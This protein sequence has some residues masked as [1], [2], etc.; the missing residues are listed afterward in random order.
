[1][2][3]RG[4]MTILR[5]THYLFLSGIF[6]HRH[7]RNCSLIYRIRLL[8][9]LVRLDARRVA[10][11]RAVV[12]A[13]EALYQRDRVFSKVRPWEGEQLPYLPSAHQLYPEHIHKQP[14]PAYPG[15]GVRA[16]VW[17]MLKPEIYSAISCI[18]FELSHSPSHGMTSN[19]S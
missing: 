9:K 13:T 7:L 6:Y 16:R 17:L 10:L 15:L 4:E 1:M 8:C 12:V 14:G 3:G 11:P 19:P 5:N 18:F 2:K